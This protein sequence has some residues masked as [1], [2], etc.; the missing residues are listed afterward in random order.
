MPRPALETRMRLAQ[1]YLVGHAM[2]H[3]VVCVWRPRSPHIMLMYIIITILRPAPAALLA[4]MH[5]KQMQRKPM[6]ADT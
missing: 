4:R 1:L 6:N 5:A 2:R 3:S